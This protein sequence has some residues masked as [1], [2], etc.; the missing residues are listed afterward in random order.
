MEPGTDI[1]PVTTPS[2][3]KRIIDIISKGHDEG[4]ELLLDGR[5]IRVDGYEKGNFVGPTVLHNVKVKFDFRFEILM[6][7]LSCYIKFN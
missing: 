5:K 4:A 2:A 7:I 1:G 3:K 6:I